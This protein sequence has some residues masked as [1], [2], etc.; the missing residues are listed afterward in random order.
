VVVC[1][2]KG[3]GKRECA[4]WM[5]MKL[6]RRSVALR[7]LSLLMLDLHDWL[8]IRL[9][10]WT[11]QSLSIMRSIQS[12]SLLIKLSPMIST[13]GLFTVSDILVSV[14]LDMVKFKNEPLY[15]SHN[16]ELLS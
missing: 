5:V 4:G 13:F 3:V 12:P 2:E 8:V 16:G 10:I 1:L 6:V 14:R 15:I 7:E 9:M 11:C